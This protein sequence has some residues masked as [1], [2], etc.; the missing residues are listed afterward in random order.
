MRRKYHTNIK[1]AF[2]L[3]I[4][5][6]SILDQIA[7]STKGNWKK[8]DLNAIFGID[9]K[10]ALKEVD[11]IK[12]ILQYRNMRKTMM[13]ANLFLKLFQKIGND[14]KN[15]KQL[16]K[17]YQLEIVDSLE[18][19]KDFMSF[20]KTLKIVGISASQ[21]RY[22]KKKVNCT[23]SPIKICRKI[24]SNQL[25]EKEVKTIRNYL[26]N[27]MEEQF[28][29]VS[30]YYKMI[31]D[32]LAFMHLSTF[33]KYASL[34]GFS[35]AYKNYR[36]SK[37]KKTGIRANGIYE[38]IHIDLTEYFLSTNQKVYI[39]SIVDNF[40][41]A[42]L[43]LKASYTKTSD[44]TFNNLKEV[45]EKHI[46]P[47]VKEKTLVMVDDGSENKGCVAEYVK[48]NDSWLKRLVARIDIS[49][50]NSMIE[51]Y[52]HKLKNIY[53]KNKSF[54]TIEGLNNYLVELKTLSNKIHLNAL[55]GLTPDMVLDGKESDP[56]IYQKEIIDAMKSRLVE[57]ANS[58]CNQCIPLVRQD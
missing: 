53:L 41:R 34:L 31:Y 4:L 32:K 22:L 20:E 23:A 7:A 33:Y 26:S 38:I 43:A 15:K 47:N 1:I 25:T 27:Y 46:F 37:H 39:C 21:Y 45:A 8:V 48:T 16:I 51:A 49:F 29:M 14:I 28:T 12:N 50:S 55:D 56:L 13:A 3:G 6:N 5:E 19:I 54:N 44:F 57:N 52:F 58:S 35:Q 30:V 9:Y 42:V 24:V 17:K 10:L 40:S 11:A 2:I 18:R 36:S